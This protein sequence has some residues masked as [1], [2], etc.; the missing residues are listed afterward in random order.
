MKVNIHI[1]KQNTSHI[2]NFLFRV[3][4]T[5]S[6]SAN[7]GTDATVFTCRVTLWSWV[8]VRMA[9]FTT[10][11]LSSFSSMFR[12]AI[13]LTRSSLSLLLEK[14]KQ[15]LRKLQHETDNHQTGK[16]VCHSPRFLYE[17]NDKFLYF[18]GLVSLKS[19]YLLQ[20]AKTSRRC[21]NHSLDLS[22]SCIDVAESVDALLLFFLWNRL[23]LSP[24]FC[25]QWS[26]GIEKNVLSYLFNRQHCVL[27]TKAWI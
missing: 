5:I 25:E 27:S 1:K 24:F 23:I 8:R 11:T 15:W 9:F 7:V 21:M 6:K 17:A 10:F 14:A 16:L 3:N 19:D 2:Q 12:L 13:S 4:Q 26:D 22:C 18:D 20:D